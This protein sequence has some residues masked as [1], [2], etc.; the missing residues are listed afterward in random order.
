MSGRPKTGHWC[1]TRRSEQLIADQ[2]RKT[3][4]ALARRARDRARLRRGYLDNKVVVSRLRVTPQQ[5]V[6]GGA[7]CLNFRLG[8][9]DAPVLRSAHDK[10]RARRWVIAKTLG[11]CAGRARLI[12]Y[13]T[14]AHAMGMCQTAAV[15]SGGLS[16]WTAVR[17]SSPVIRC[18]STKSVT[19][20]VCTWTRPSRRWCCAWMKSRYRRWTAHCRSCR[21][22]QVFLSAERTTTC[23]MERRLFAALDIATGGGLDS[24][25]GAIAASEFC[26]SCVPLKR[27]ASP[28][29]CAF[30]DGQSR[31]RTRPLRWGHGLQDTP[32]PRA[33]HAHLASPAQS[34]ERY[35]NP[36]REYIRRGTDQN[37]TV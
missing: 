12:E 29:G 13:R 1:W 28:A 17:R 21:W 27:N 3:A 35:F 2:R 33:L 5:T 32:V 22:H 26:S 15:E 7:F 6:S 20:S 4:Q 18:L 34:V 9:L 23:A 36:D 11:A 14:M 16:V 24:Y 19:S 30:G 8:L 31:H 10:T 25:I 37:E